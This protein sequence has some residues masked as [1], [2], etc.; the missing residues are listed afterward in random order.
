MFDHE[1]FAESTASYTYGR[2]INQFESG[3][4]GMYNHG[5][6]LYEFINEETKEQTGFFPYPIINPEVNNGELVPMFGAFIHANAQNTAEARAFLIYLAGQASQQ[7]NVDSLMRVASNLLVDPSSYD[8]VHAQ[9][10]ALV[11]QAGY[12]TQLY[13]ANTH[14]DVAFRGYQM[15]AQ[16][17]QNHNDPETVDFILAEWEKVR[18]EAYGDLE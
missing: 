17:W 16:F 3:E 11:E 15:I 14:P 2:A 5:E 7:N 18:Q 6:W 12:I 4:I 10:L 9:G 13:G 1:C 8:E